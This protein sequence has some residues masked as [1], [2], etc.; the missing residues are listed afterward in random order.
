[1]RKENLK[2]HKEREPHEKMTT[3]SNGLSA[4]QEVL[5]DKEFKNAD[6]AGKD[7]NKVVNEKNKP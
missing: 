6:S 7:K 2:M 3:K 5:Y 1:M 4:T